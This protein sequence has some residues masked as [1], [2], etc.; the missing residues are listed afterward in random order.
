MKKIIL[1]FFLSTLPSMVFWNAFTEVEIWDITLKYISYDISSD[2]YNIKVWI[3]EDAVTLSELSLEYNGISAI[4]G[5]FFCPEDYSQCN[6]LNY[7]INERFIDGEDLSFYTN[8]GE[9]WIF[10]WTEEWTPFIHKTEEINPNFRDF[11][12]EWLWNFPILLENGEYMLDHYIDIGLYDK[13]MSVSA[14]RHFI[15]SNHEKTHIYIGRSSG[16]SLEWLTP[17]L[18]KIGCWD[19]LNLDAGKSSHFNYNWQEIV[20]WSRKV[21]DGIVIQ[22]TDLDILSIENNTNL[23]MQKIS[24]YTSKYPQVTQ[25]KILDILLDYIS[26]T[27]SDIYKQYSVD[28]YDINWDYIWY[29][30][31]ITSLSELRKVYTLNI[32][33]T[34]IQKLYQEIK[35]H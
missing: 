3:S 21:I 23:S 5:V 30:V 32:L 20:K 19:A 18:Y 16:T 22:R 35:T 13:K 12:Y 17:A 7:T 25:L 24:T 6:G 27:R 31:D 11:I 33:E 14:P 28:N 15:C 2:I 26:K 29:T 8:T 1:V 10:W 34:K 4:N 9:R